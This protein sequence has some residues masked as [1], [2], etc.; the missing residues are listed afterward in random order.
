M[1]VSARIGINGLFLAPN[2]GG[3]WTYFSNLMRELPYLDADIAYTLFSN[4]RIADQ[5][6]LT[7]T[8]N[9]RARALVAVGGLQSA[10]LANA[11]FRLPLEARQLRLTLLWSPTPFAP[12]RC[13][14]ASVVTLHDVRHEDLAASASRS[15]RTLLATL[16]RRSAHSATGILTVSEY[17]K[18]RIARVYHIPTE[19]ISV[20][21]NAAAPHY[22]DRVSDA[23]HARVRQHYG[24]RPPYILSAATSHPHKNPEVLLEAFAALRRAGSTA[25]LVLFGSRQLTGELLQKKIRAEGIEADVVLTGYVPDGDL[26]ALYQGASAFVLPSRYEG[27]GLPVLE[28][29]ASGVPVLTTT[30]T[31]LPEVAGDAALLFDPDD[32][33]ALVAGM[34][35]VLGDEALHRELVGRG[36][37]RARQFTWRKSAEVTLA[38]FQRAMLTSSIGHASTRTQP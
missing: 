29:M 6:H 24:L 37:A 15:E 35:R 27:F 28:A 34:E 16:A 30:A 1:A 2:G 18:Q 11:F 8:D 38:A 25:Q 23:E 9:L 33:G 12:L 31:A 36:H 3:I 4:H 7:E 20:A 17:A 22:F 14:C 32:R 5:F 13:G 19:R 21:Y 26:P 10:R